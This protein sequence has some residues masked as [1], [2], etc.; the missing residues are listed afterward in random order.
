MLK[1]FDMN[2]LHVFYTL[3]EERNV[4]RTAE[5]LGRTQSAVSNA[6]KRLRDRFDDPL[7][8]RTQGGLV[9]TPLATELGQTVENIVFLT[10]ECL[11]RAR[12]FDPRTAEARFAIGAPDRLSLPVIMPFLKSLKDVAPKISI[13]VRT[14]DRDQAI[15]LI[16]QHEIELA[17]GW[18]DQVPPHFGSSSTFAEPLVCLVR[19][20][21]PLLHKKEA[22]TLDRVLAFPHLVVTSSGD[23]KAAFDMM[24]V[25]MG[26]MRTTSISLSNFTMVP[27]LLQESDLI[28]VFTQRTADYLA[29]HY[30]LATH[31]LPLE[32]EPISHRLIWHRRFNADKMH[33]WLRH[34]LASHCG[35]NPTL[36]ADRPFDGPGMMA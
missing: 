32:V 19:V 18:F 31:S 3:L 13:D 34:Q 36:E 4:T 14:A 17:L 30:G 8:V 10:D 27:G 35:I 5:K 22:V 2:L 6:L 20:D 21:H 25:R 26:L 33:R 28:G 29:Q 1:R 24:L 15:R 11:N 23:R 12:G 16:D 9:P 7:F